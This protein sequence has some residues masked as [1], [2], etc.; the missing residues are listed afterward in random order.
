MSAA[1]FT[2]NWFTDESCA[3]LSD[4]VRTVE[5][6]P[7]RIVELG[8]WEGRST[9]AIARTTTRDVHAVDHWKGAKSDRYQR[10]QVK[11]RDVFAQWT[12][13]LA[14]YPHVTPYRMEWRSYVSRTDGPVALVFID[15]DH[16]T[17]E[18]SAQID[19]FAP[20]MSRGGIICGD[21]YPM[22]EVWKAVRD[23]LGTVSVEGPVWSWQA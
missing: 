22:V 4:L 1:E 18:V 5:G 19:T 7:G 16:T 6:V 20:L 21:D 11:T 8:S 10:Q 14:G 9:I 23:R 12:A 17:A 15:A 2:E 13:N 3:T